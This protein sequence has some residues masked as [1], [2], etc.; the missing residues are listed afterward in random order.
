MNI[1]TVTA[2]KNAALRAVLSAPDFPQNAVGVLWRFDKNQQPLGEAG[3]FT[4]D[5]PSV[6]IGTAED[7]A[8]QFFL[9]EGAVLH[10][11]DSPPTPYRTLVTILDGD[12]V[13]SREIPKDGGEG[14]VGTKDVPFV[15]RFTVKVNA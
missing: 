15:Y 5:T 13:I 14:Q 6:S 9:L 1:T 3:A 2:R 12:D 10:Q 8:G 4:P 7:I 11:N